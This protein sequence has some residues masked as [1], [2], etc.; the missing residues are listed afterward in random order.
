VTT[1]VDVDVETDGVVVVVLV[2]VLLPES[3]PPHAVANGTSAVAHMTAMAAGRRIARYLMS[4]LPSG[5][6]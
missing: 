1:D 4:V 3:F 2:V 6:A 5:E